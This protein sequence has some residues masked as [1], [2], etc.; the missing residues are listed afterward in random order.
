M[1]EAAT[2]FWLGILTSIS[3]CPLASNI[4][5]LS[6]CLRGTPSGRGA[7][8]RGAAYSVG[9]AAAYAG[10]AML[11][12]LAGLSIPLVSDLLQRYINKALG[13]V[14]ILTGVVLLGLLPLSFGAWRPSEAWTSRLVSGGALG[15]AGMGFLLALAFCPVSA[16]IFF[17]AL[18]PL[19]L[20]SGSSAWLPFVYGIATGLPVLCFAAAAA[21]GAAA[22][23]RNYEKAAVLERW[24]RPATGVVLVSLG[25]YFTLRY[26][27]QVL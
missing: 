17:G 5:A 4:A 27:F 8:G 23:A 12:A 11:I 6:F 1:V 24:A 21:G 13:P 25:I 9:R 15:S 16:A 2:A 18:I 20:R 10:L 26:I 14:L 22:V 19:A 3:P 7:A